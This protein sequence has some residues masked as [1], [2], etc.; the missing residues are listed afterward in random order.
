M[1]AEP[2]T[3]AGSTAGE[4]LSRESEPSAPVPSADAAGRS[5]PLAWRDRIFLH[6]AIMLFMAVFLYVLR[7]TLSP[8]LLA[9]S[10]FLL[11][12]ITK[13]GI[14]FETGTA[15]LA[16]FLITAWF[17]GEVAALL[18]PFLI[19]FVLAYLM[20]PLVKLM[21]RRISRT[22]AIGLLALL[23]LGVLSGTAVLLIPR[24]ID[25]LRVFAE[26]MPEYATG[27]QEFVAR[28]L[29]YAATH[30]L[31]M[32]TGSE[33]QERISGEIPQVGSLFAEQT[34][35]VLKRLTSGLAALLNMLMIPFVT[36]YVLK[37]YDRIVGT[38]QNALPRRYTGAA[39]GVL[40]TLDRILGQYVRG[41]VLVC[42]F[43]AVLTSVGLA[44]SGLNYAVLL[45]T[46]AGVLNLLPYVGLAISFSV[47]SLIAVLGDDPV[48]ALLKVVVVFVVVQSIEGNFLSPRLVGRRVGLHPAWVMF[49]LVVGAH[50]WGFIGLAV[51]IP[52]AAVVNV[53]IQV[54]GG[55][56]YSSDYYGP[57]APAED[58]E[59]G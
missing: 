5:Q 48:S 2:N 15:V 25:E 7:D 6:I 22:L 20:A 18:W 55:L 9:G 29:D 17:V 28:L 16:G 47:A 51:A 1:E 14:G 52:A 19:S 36:F 4:D 27:V 42:S 39:M 45:G 59:D 50:F 35:A 10:L 34:T 3:L 12:F 11:I 38:M 24:V 57:R 56:Y 58:R 40:Q 23:V 21:S 37:D 33:L 53:L 32:P 41:Q 13:R 43:I 46:M 30:G 49:A 26:R 54:L 44:I 8:L 31:K